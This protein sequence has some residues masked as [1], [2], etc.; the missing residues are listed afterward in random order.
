MPDTDPLTFAAEWHADGR[1]VAIA[2]VIETWRLRATTG[3][4]PSGDRCAG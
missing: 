4:K 1:D 3:G 2:T